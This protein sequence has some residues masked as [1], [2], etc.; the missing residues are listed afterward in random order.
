[1]TSL[2]MN[3]ISAGRRIVA[4]GGG[5]GLSTLLRGLKHRVPHASHPGR[6][7][8][9]PHSIFISNLTAIVA[10]TDDGGSS[11]RLRRELNLLPPGDL[12]NCLV[13]L[14][15]DEQVFS[16]LFC[17]R[18][19]AGGELGGHSFGNLFIAAL[20]EMTGDFAQAI[21]LAGEVLAIR[22]HILPATTVHASLIATMEDGSLVRG[23]TRISASRQ[24]I[25]GGKLEPAVAPASAETLQAIAA[26]DLITL[27]PGSLYTSLITNL[28]V[29]GIPE[30]LTSARAT[31]VY[32]ANLMTEANESLGL[33]VADHIERI[34][35]HA[36]RPIFDYAL[37]NT[38][39]ISSAIQ[40]RYAAEGAEPTKADIKR[41]EAMGI[42]C[43]T[44]DFVADG[45]LFRHEPERVTEA[46]LALPCA[47]LPRQG[48]GATISWTSHRN[49]R[50]MSS[51][52]REG[53][54]IVQSRV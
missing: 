50:P 33:S 39:P 42:R 20:T 40:E 18:F 24:R 9:D 38:G 2:F 52:G 47:R 37:V 54:G 35:D 29:S 1:M 22:G 3:S 17:H 5:T 15:G 6:E 53:E 23:E 36:G 44:G 30:A 43:I 31:R 34:Y 45:D 28:L 19:R 12:R 8:L 16:R 21:K 26:A 32:I 46:L 41:I 11:G 49:Q 51:S 14:A 4:I 48:D 13:A 27:G 7:S 10:V 25:V